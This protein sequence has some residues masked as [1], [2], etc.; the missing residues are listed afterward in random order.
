MFFKHVFT[1]GS[2]YSKETVV[3]CNFFVLLF[4]W[5]NKN[6]FY[7]KLETSQYKENV[8]IN[9]IKLFVQY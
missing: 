1:F 7:K 2:S 9:I 6:E 8:S 3:P 4:F 5:R